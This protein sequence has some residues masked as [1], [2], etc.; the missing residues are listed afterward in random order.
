[1]DY[2]VLEAFD[3]ELTAIP[4]IV[5]ALDAI[6][7]PTCVASNGGHAKMRHT[8]GLT[9]LLD[10]FEGRIFSRSDVRQGKPAPDLFLY[11]PKQM[12]VVPNRCVVVEDS[13]TGIAAAKAAGIRAL[14]FAATTPTERLHEADLTF[15]SMSD[16]PDLLAA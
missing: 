3:A 8:L 4:G 5:E 10:R 2:A 1:M 9:G 16:L 7:L 12:G 6:T 15:T 11:A 13:P 14:V